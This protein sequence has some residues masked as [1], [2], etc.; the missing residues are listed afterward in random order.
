MDRSLLLKARRLLVEM[1]YRARIGHLGGNL[2]CIDALMVAH[3]VA[4]GPEDR[5]IL[6]KGHAAGAYYV[7]LA[8]KGLIPAEELASFHQDGTR[9]AGHPP[10]TGVPGIR[11]ATG[12]LGHGLSLAAGLAL[13]ARMRGRSHRVFCLTSDGEW[14]EGS[15][16]EA[17]IFAMHHRLSNLTVLVDHNRLQGFGG[18]AEVASMEPLEARLQGFGVEIRHCDGH[19]PDAIAAAMR[20]GSGSPCLVM[21]ET[22][23][24]SGVPS[25]EGRMESHYLPPTEVQL[26]ESMRLGSPA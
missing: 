21:L 16:F 5:F 26:G 13:A 14:Q 11:F 25:M 7:T 15:T 19:D 23:K 12:S 22:V 6:S 1:H 8:M 18:T 10:A 4:M 17:L 20:P 24:G 3:F 9:L 2:S